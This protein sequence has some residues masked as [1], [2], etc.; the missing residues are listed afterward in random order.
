MP[1]VKIDMIKGVRSPE[2]IKKLADVVQEVMLQ[3]FNAPARDRYG[4]LFSILNM[5]FLF[6]NQLRQN[7]SYL[8]FHFTPS[9]FLP[10]ISTSPSYHSDSILQLPND[11]PTRALRTHLRR[12]EPP[13]L[14]HQ[15][16]RL[17]PD[18][19]ARPKR[20][21]QASYLRR[22]PETVGGRVWCAR[23]GSDY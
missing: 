12:H 2:E 22:A 8:A 3:K 13:L 10:T 23:D 9:S 11:N 15:Q 4:F 1:L 19:P 20:R 7:Q 21:A 5:S 6:V 14:T 17:H 18:L 16:A